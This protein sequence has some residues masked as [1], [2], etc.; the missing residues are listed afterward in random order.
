MFKIRKRQINT[1]R[2]KQKLYVYVFEL[3]GFRI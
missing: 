3:F 1:T 2:R